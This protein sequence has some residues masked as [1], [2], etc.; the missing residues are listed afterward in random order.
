M[1]KW[2]VTTMEQLGKIAFV[3][4]YVPRKC[5]IATFT[6]D[7]RTAIAGQY[8]EADCIVVPVNDLEEGYAYP[9]EV[10]FEFH[11]RDPK[12]YRQAADFLNFNNVDA[13]SLQHEFGI[14]G[15]PEGRH[16]LGLLRDVRVPTVT[17]LHTVL[18][19]PTPDQRRVMADLTTLSARLVVM[20]QKGRELL[21]EVYETDPDR[22]DV[23]PHG[24]PDMPFYDPSF[25]KEQYGVKGK[26]VLLTFGLLSP[27]KGIEYALQALPAIREAYPEVVYIVLGAT[28]PNTLRER[29]E[30]YRL[31][32]ERLAKELGVEKNVVFYDRFVDIEELKQFLA[33]ADIYITPYLYEAQIT[34][35]TLAYAFGCGKAV[36]STPY[37][38]ASELLADE[39]GVLVPFRDPAAIAQGVISLLADEARLN[40]MRKRAYLLG[41]EM[42]W[43]NIAHR[44]V[45]SFLHA[46]RSRQQ[47]PRVLRTMDAVEERGAALP[48]VRLDHLV[49]LTDGTGLLQHARF[50]LPRLEEGY[51][52]DD[53]ARAL[54]LSVLLEEL[55]E[56]T[57]EHERLLIRFAAFLDYAFDRP[58]GLRGLGAQLLRRPGRPGRECRR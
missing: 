29:G 19:E 7:L 33:A 42:V 3:S 20:T 46:R 50:T 4:D 40:A 47:Q 44:Y 49:Q 6:H 53:N 10:R 32:L 34:S 31:S 57:P 24:I 1:E 38:H 18:R 5:G 8:P 41:R 21:A 48:R 36:V 14:F 56:A 26:R 28:H 11:E 35:G 45:E 30:L 12:S 27:N 58:D 22:V 25:Y 15:G 37:W 55:D 51:C 9:P 2:T 43:S 16:I 54:L 39:H 52:T 23:I 17:T 13:V